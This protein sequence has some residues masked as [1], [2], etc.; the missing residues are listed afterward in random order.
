[1]FQLVQLFLSK[2]GGI[3]QKVLQ[4]S[5][6]FLGKSTFSTGFFQPKPSK[7]VATPSRRFQQELHFASTVMVE[8]MWHS[9]WSYFRHTWCRA[10][11]GG[12]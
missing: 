11:H 1:M 5:G 2:F 12:A 8:I 7:T 6:G 9:E 10:Q 4:Y 3:F